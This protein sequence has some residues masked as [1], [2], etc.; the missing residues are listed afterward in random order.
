MEGEIR[1]K[2]DDV[3]KIRMIIDSSVLKSMIEGDTE[4]MGQQFTELLKKMNDLENKKHLE[5]FTT[6]S[7]LFRA[8]FLSNEKTNINN[9]QKIL[10]FISIVPSFADFKNEEAVRNEII[11]VAKIFTGVRK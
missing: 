11:E 10:S 8:I 6:S 5:V 4:K 3:E 1:K 7:S 9:L 2:I